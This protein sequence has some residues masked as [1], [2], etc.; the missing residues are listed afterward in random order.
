MDKLKRTP[1]FCELDRI[2]CDSS[3]V[4]MKIKLKA[5]ISEENKEKIRR[6]YC[7]YKYL[8]ILFIRTS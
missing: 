4:R 6:V 5:N 3:P 7:E 2:M 8:Q 1:K